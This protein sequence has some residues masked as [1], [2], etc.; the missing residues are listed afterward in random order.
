M[1]S[2][3]STYDKNNIHRL[4]AGR[5]SAVFFVAV[6]YGFLQDI[7]GKKFLSEDNSI[8]WLDSISVSPHGQVTPYFKK[9]A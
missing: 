7:I 4:T 3:Q 2:V 9:E 8:V 1:P 6:D 5:G